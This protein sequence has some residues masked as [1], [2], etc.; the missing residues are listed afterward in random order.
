MGRLA[1]VSQN[2]H[3]LDDVLLR[4]PAVLPR[5]GRERSVLLD[6]VFR[7]ASIPART[8]RL[9]A[10]VSERPHRRGV[11]NV[12]NYVGTA[13]SAVHRAQRGFSRKSPVAC[14]QLL[15]SLRLLLRRINNHTSTPPATAPSSHEKCCRTS[16]PVS[17]TI[18]G[19]NQRVSSASTMKRTNLPA[20][21]AA[22]KSR[23][24]ISNTAAPSTKSLNGVGG[25]SIPGNIRAQNSC[26]SNER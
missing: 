6:R 2:V 13:V 3:R 15:R 16:V 4:R 25:G 22:R 9:D 20:K 5:N 11:E 12:E 23:N 7:N 1:D 26:C 21:T 18:R 8:L 10:Q 19:P 17:S 24:R 14:G